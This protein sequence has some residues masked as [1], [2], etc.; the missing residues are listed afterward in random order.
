METI[1]TLLKEMDA[2]IKEQKKS[3][4]TLKEELAPDIKSIKEKIE[5]QKSSC[6]T[7]AQELEAHLDKV[8]KLL[9]NLHR[10]KGPPIVND[11]ILQNL[12]GQLAGLISGEITINEYR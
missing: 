7:E 5:Q 12:S 10:R 3:F 11:Q 6:S 8:E 2:Y 4:A 1:T 9:N